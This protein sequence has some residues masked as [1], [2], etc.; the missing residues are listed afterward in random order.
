ML[1]LYLLQLTSRHLW[2]VGC[3]SWLS[4]RFDPQGCCDQGQRH[5]HVSH[6]GLDRPKGSKARETP[7]SAS[8]AII[9][10]WR[11]GVILAC[12]LVRLH[13]AMQP[14]SY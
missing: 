11:C 8:S 4:P 9:P 13:F 6:W 2:A 3:G 10:P 1:Y 12:R 14:S 5:S 7:R